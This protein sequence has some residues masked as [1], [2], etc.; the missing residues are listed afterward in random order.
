MR[1]CPERKRN[2]TTMAKAT[3]ATPIA[4]AKGSRERFLRIAAAS[5]KVPID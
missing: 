5:S 1:T 4:A 2:R 3:P